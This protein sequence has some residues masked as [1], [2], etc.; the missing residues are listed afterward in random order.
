[1][2]LKTSVAQLTEHY[3]AQA[4]VCRE[5]LRRLGEGQPIS[6]SAGEQQELAAAIAELRQDEGITTPRKL[7]SDKG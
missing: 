1:M 7:P 3:E 4:E 5:H 2:W 6:R